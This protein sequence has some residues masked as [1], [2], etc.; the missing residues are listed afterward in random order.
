MER[1]GR[2]TAPRNNRQSAAG[3][4]MSQGEDEP[5]E[6]DKNRASL[7][8]GVV[9]SSPRASDA[10]TGCQQVPTENVRRPAARIGGSYVRISAFC[11]EGNFQ[12]AIA[13]HCWNR[14]KMGWRI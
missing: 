14:G 7:N 13:F 12:S 3:G 2:S 4:A 10:R 9:M 8:R 1:E 5:D 11:S 6:A